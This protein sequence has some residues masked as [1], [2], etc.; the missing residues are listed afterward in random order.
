MNQVQRI[1]VLAGATT[2][3]G[4]WN[5]NAN[6]VSYERAT[7]SVDGSRD[8]LTSAGSAQSVAKRIDNMTDRRGN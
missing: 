5:A 8:A 3:A 4:T 7:F 1:P 6:T 2:I